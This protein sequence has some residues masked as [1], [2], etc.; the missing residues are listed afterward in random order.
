MAEETAFEN[1]RILNFQGLVTLT[2]DRVLLHTI[3]HHSSTFN[4][5]QFHWN[6]RNFLWTDVWTYVH[7]HGHLRLALL[8]DRVNL[9]STDPNQSPGLIHSSSTTG[10]W[11]KGHHCL[12]T[13]SPTPVPRTE[14]FKRDWQ[15]SMLQMLK[16]S[17]INRF[18]KECGQ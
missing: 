10:L 4:Y 9:R 7:T 5:L 17:A 1:G 8:G 16:I 13:D 3:V 15:M 2:L 6:Q 11:W 12:Y 18:A 14:S